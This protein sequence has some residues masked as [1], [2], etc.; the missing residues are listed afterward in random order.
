MKITKNSYGILYVVIH[1][2]GKSKR[3]GPGAYE[4]LSEEATKYNAQVLLM[5]TRSAS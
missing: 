5:R 4:L 2:R 1:L 3:S